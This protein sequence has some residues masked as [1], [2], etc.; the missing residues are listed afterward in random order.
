VTLLNLLAAILTFPLSIVWYPLYLMS[1]SR[2]KKTVAAIQA[3][4]VAIQAQ[5]RA[6][7]RKGEWV[8]DSVYEA[9]NGKKYQVR[10]L[11]GDDKQLTVE[12]E[13]GTLTLVFKGRVK[14]LAA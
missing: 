6:L 13:D 14:P 10:N 5:T 8:A 7:S 4:T 11:G 9:F 12:S 2:G 3:Q 1:K